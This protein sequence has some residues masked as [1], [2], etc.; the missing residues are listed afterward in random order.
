MLVVFFVAAALSPVM[1]VVWVVVWLTADAIGRRAPRV[2]YAVR[3]VPQHHD[4][5]RRI[6]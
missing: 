2:P 3:A 5:E 6:A 4:R 1:V